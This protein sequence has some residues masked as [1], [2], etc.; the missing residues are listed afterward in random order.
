MPYNVPTFNLTARL[1][2]ISTPL[3]NPP[4]LVFLSQLR[5]TP[6]SIQGQMDWE[7]AP[8]PEPYPQTQ[9]FSILLCCP[10]L[11]DIRGPG[12]DLV[13]PFNGDWVQV[14]HTG[15]IYSVMQVED[16]TKGFPNEYRI[17]ALGL[18][19]KQFPMD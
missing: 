6:R 4:D 19:Y 2:H 12:Y 16:V 9:M 3:A 8:I 13:A 17:A 15:W 5:V 11:T 14:A 10:K 7:Q 1:W 18:A